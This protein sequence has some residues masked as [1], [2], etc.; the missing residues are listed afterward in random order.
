VKI[1][2]T[3]M[4]Y[5]PSITEVTVSRETP[6]TYKI[7]KRSGKDLLNYVW[8]PEYVRKDNI[9]FTVFLT[10]EDALNH[11]DGR[12]RDRIE[13]EERKILRLKEELE[14]VTWALEDLKENND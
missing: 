4:R 9:G 7:K 8:V 13:A 14:A 6:K 12:I 11:L 3:E 10:L 2:L 1:Y 5:K